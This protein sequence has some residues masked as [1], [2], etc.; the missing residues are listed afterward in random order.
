MSMPDKED[1]PAVKLAESSKLMAFAVKRVP[2]AELVSGA[3]KQNNRS[4]LGYFAFNAVVDRYEDEFGSPAPARNNAI[5]AD[6]V[7]DAAY[8]IEGALE[9]IPHPLSFDQ[10]LN[11]FKQPTTIETLALM[12]MHGYKKDDELR[13]R[14]SI[15]TLLAQ[16]GNAYMPNDDYTA[17][18]PGA[19]V[20]PEPDGCPAAG[21][22]ET[23]TVNPL[24]VFRQFAVWSGELALR[25]F[26]YLD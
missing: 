11:I 2:V 5:F 24:P 23:M 20:K 13:N 10:A 4:L 17:I 7:R 19:H 9:R 22:Y 15:H 12:A 26:H 21:D 18:I 6:G 3:R 1:S 16:P 25:T 8:F 14:T